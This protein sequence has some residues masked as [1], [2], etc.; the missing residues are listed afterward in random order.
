DT[1]AEAV[2]EGSD[3]VSAGVSYD[4]AGGAEVELLVTQDF[5]G[6]GAINLTGNE[7]AQTIQGNEGANTLSGLGDNDVLH[8]LGGA[9]ALL[10]GAGNDVLNGGTGADATTGGTG[11]DTH[12]V[13][14]AGDTV[15]EAAGE[16][17]ADRVLT[18]IGF[19]LGAA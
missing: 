4:L 3:R 14:N 12:Y 2:G 17:A 6:T 13:D 8:G 18:S 19:T 1:V 15:N 16:G 9:D 10:G 7:F 11:D 5:A